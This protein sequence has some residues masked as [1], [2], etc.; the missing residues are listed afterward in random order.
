[1]SGNMTNYIK[2]D[3][4]TK[5]FKDEVVLN[6]ISFE[7]EKGKTYGFIGRNGSGKTVIFKLIA[8]LLLPSS[9]NILIEEENVTKSKKFISDM[10]ILIETPGFI[11]HYSGVKNLQVLNSLSHNKVSLQ[12]IK[13]S[14]ELV[15]LDPNSKKPVKSYSLG[16]K[17][18]LGIAQ[19]VM[20]RP[21]LLILDEPMNGLDEKSVENMREFFI[22][23]REEGATILLASHNKEDI[24][25]LCDK[26]FYISE[27]QVEVKI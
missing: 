26:I 8:G 22:K 20:N 16:M 2:F 13:E 5:R 9:G 21:K 19:A 17:Q 7:L 4:V 11:P 27:G 10:G 18:K 24:S 15:G 6:D 25:I 3:K 12:N 23:L 1:M 14:I